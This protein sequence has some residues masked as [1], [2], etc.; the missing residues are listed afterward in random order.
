MSW[1]YKEQKVLPSIAT[2]EGGESSLCESL[3]VRGGALI[4]LSFASPVPPAAILPPIP[5]D[6]NL[7]PRAPEMAFPDQNLGLTVLVPAWDIM[8][9]L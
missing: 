4:M 7:P 1:P 5:L 6:Q 8:A 2:I 3:T 9:Y